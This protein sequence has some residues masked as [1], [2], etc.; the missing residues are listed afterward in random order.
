M[1]LS[2]GHSPAVRATRPSSGGSR[3]MPC[4]SGPTI[5]RR[6]GCTRCRR[7]H[8]SLPQDAGCIGRWEPNAGF[9]ASCPDIGEGAVV[10]PVGKGLFRLIVELAH[11]PVT[12]RV[13]FQPQPDLFT[14][15]DFSQLGRSQILPRGTARI[16]ADQG[17]GNSGQSIVGVRRVHLALQGDHGPHVVDVP[18]TRVP[19]VEKK[20]LQCGPAGSRKD[21]PGMLP[22]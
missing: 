19:G 12:R 5:V 15:F 13:P 20:K 6:A 2:R 22:P 11:D 14:H 3:T 10:H 17:I 8:G 9:A 21:S 7:R 4:H 18:V 16:G 1:D